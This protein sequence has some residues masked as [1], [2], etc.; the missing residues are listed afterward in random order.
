VLKWTLYPNNTNDEV[1]G[2][3]A[4]IHNRIEL[5]EDDVGKRRPGTVKKSTLVLGQKTSDKAQARSA[6]SDEP[7]DIKPGVYQCEVIKCGETDYAPVESFTI[8]S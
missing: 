3:S 8:K 6:R 1:Q 5:E 7:H 4:G 2:R